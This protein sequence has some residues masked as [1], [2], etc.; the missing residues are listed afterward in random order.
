MGVGRIASFLSSLSPASDAAAATTSAEPIPGHDRAAEHTAAQ[1]DRDR[2]QQA[3]GGDLTQQLQTMIT[4]VRVLN[5]N[6]V[7]QGAAV[8]VSPAGTQLM[9]AVS[10]LGHLLAAV[11]PGALTPGAEGHLR[12]AA[13]VVEGVEAGLMATQTA[14]Q[15]IL[16]QLPLQQAAAAREASDRFQNQMRDALTRVRGALGTLLN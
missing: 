4:A 2:R 8:A 16:A 12:Q 9:N 1:Q 10:G 13:H 15:A 3:D 5:E 6:A 11:D 14:S 7:Q